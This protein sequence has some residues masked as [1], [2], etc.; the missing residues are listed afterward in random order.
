[1][2]GRF[3][4]LPA[5]YILLACLLISVFF[6]CKSD[7]DIQDADLSEAETS[8]VDT[9]AAETEPPDYASLL[10]EEYGYLYTDL[11]QVI[12]NT[13]GAEIG[14]P[15]L[16]A[17]LTVVEYIDGRIRIVDDDNG[18]IKIRGNTTASTE[19]K[20][21]SIRFEEKH[22]LIGMDSGK[23]WVLQASVFDKSLMRCKLVCD[24]FSET[25]AALCVAGRI[26]RS[27]AQRR[28]PRLISFDGAGCGG[29]RAGRYQLA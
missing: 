7:G 17:S 23:R 14:W 21:F 6:S 29:Q 22:S 10:P 3:L 16:P 24:F 11:P 4:P 2:K 9:N 15:Y 26:L 28:I 1:M 13:G 19:K 12:I 8:A 20:S 25:P 18:Q 5:A 27:L